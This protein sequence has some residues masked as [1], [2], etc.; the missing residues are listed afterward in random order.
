M[1]K[2]NTRAGC[3]IFIWN[4]STCPPLFCTKPFQVQWKSMPGFKHRQL[5]KLLD[6]RNISIAPFHLLPQWKTRP[7]AATERRSGVWAADCSGGPAVIIASDP[8]IPQGKET[9]NPSLQEGICGSMVQ[10]GEAFCLHLEN[11]GATLPYKMA[12]TKRQHP[13]VSEKGSVSHV[14]RDF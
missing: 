12:E 8:A 11:L 13:R 6:V 4:I 1:L 5:G 2:K 7:T 9:A 3:F 10:M 14:C